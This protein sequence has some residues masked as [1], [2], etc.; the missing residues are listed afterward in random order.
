MPELDAYFCLGHWHVSTNLSGHRSY[1]QVAFTLDRRLERVTRYSAP[2]FL[3]D[4]HAGDTA[5][6]GFR[7]QF[8]MS[9]TRVGESVLVA[10]GVNDCSSA[11]LSLTVTMIDSMLR[12]GSGCTD[13]RSARTADHN[14]LSVDCG[15]ADMPEPFTCQQLGF[16]VSLQDGLVSGSSGRNIRPSFLAWTLPQHS[17]YLTGWITDDTSNFRLV[18]DWIRRSQLQAPT[19]NNS[20][21]IDVGGNHGFY[22]IFSALLEGVRRVDYFEPQAA[23]RNRAC[24]GILSNKV[25][26]VIRVHGAGIGSTS[27]RFRVVGDEGTA[28]LIE[29][30]R[31]HAAADACVDTYTLDAL[32]MPPCRRTLGSEKTHASWISLLKIDNEGWEISALLGGT[33]LLASRFPPTGLG[34][35]L[36]G[37]LLIEIAPGRWADRSRVS[38]TNGSAALTRLDAQLGFLIWLGTRSNLICPHDLALRLRACSKGALCETS[39]KSVHGFRGDQWTPVESDEVEPL[40]NR[41]MRHGR[42]RKRGQECTCNLWFEHRSWRRGVSGAVLARRVQRMASPAFEWD[43]LPPVSNR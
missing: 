14:T 24:A 11:A 25:G 38:I 9:A 34:R 7:I 33:R 6:L 32:Y 20:I 23:L 21:V 3:P 30:D 5:R 2:F 28:H 41:M 39:E 17:R 36:I 27:G 40:I 42:T 18:A 13:D 29:C 37:A 10:Y 1:Y 16:A 12:Y 15:G 19:H 8:L 35:Q 26:H 4:I 43:I 22:S 31:Q